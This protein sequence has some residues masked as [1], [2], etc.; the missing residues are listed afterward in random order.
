M[1]IKAGSCSTRPE[2]FPTPGVKQRRRVPIPARNRA[3]NSLQRRAVTYS[4]DAAPL[5]DD[6]CS[7]WIPDMMLLNGDRSCGQSLS[8]ATSRSTS[9]VGRRPAN[10]HSRARW[11]PR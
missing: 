2:G 1:E 3:I 9:R 4:S 11:C 10:L 8:T 6:P 5:S 7:A